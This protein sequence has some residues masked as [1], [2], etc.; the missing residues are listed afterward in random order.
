MQPD[1]P[2]GKGINLRLLARV[3]KVFLKHKGGTYAVFLDFLGLHQKGATGAE[4]SN[5]EAALFVRQPVSI[6][7]PVGCVR[8]LVPVVSPVLSPKGVWIETLLRRKMHCPT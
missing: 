2:D 6:P 3:L 1:H 4:R 8:C 5:N 7:R